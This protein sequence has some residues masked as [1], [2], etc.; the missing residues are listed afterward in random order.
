MAGRWLACFRGRPRPSRG[1]HSTAAKAG[2]LDKVEGGSLRR[3]WV[4]IRECGNCRPAIY[5]GTRVKVTEYEAVLLLM[6]V[7]PGTG[8]ASTF[9]VVFCENWT[10]WP[11]LRNVI[12]LRSPGLMI[13][14]FPRFSIGC[15]L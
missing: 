6:F 4:A 9:R 14:I 15:G 11:R 10:I 7:S 8:F 3:V 1:P 12:A 2:C 13:W 5:Y